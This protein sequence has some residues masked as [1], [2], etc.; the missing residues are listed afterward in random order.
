MTGHQ[1][2]PA[3]GMTLMGEP[4]KEVDIEALCKA[5]GIENV[6]TLNPHDIPDFSAGDF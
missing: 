4:T 6:R 5:I 2:N 3:S 1:Q